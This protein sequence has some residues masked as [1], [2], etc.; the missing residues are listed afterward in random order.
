MIDNGYLASFLDLGL[1]GGAVMLG[2]AVAGLILALRSSVRRAQLEPQ[3]AFAIIV[4]ILVL[5]QS[6]APV[7]QE[8]IG[9]FFWLGLL[10]LAEPLQD[11]YA[12]VSGTAELD[13][14]P[15]KTGAMT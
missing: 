1:I 15:T 9:M 8:E 11:R 10:L 7:F 2:L 6:S 4:I 12:V 14:V 3:G 5:A 13:H